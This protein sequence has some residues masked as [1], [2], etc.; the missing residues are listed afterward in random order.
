MTRLRRFFACL[1]ALIMPV[2]SA[3]AAA[4]GLSRDELRALAAASRTDVPAEEAMFLERPSV[5]APYDAGALE[6]VL[7]AAALRRANFLRAVAG[8]PP[9]NED[10]RYTALAQHAAVLMAAR[11][12]VSHRP[13]QPDDMDDA[14]FRQAAEGAAECAL[15]SFN[16]FSPT[17][18]AGCVD[19]FA[20]DDTA[21]NLSALAHRRWLLNPAMANA[22]FGLALDG[23][24]RSYVALYVT[25]DGASPDYDFI[26]WP[27]EGAFPAELMR[28]E[29][30]WSLSPNPA[31]C[32]L[33]LGEP[34]VLLEELTSGARWAFDPAEDDGERGGAYCVIDQRAF[35]GG[36]ALIFRPDLLDHPALEDGYEQNQRWRVTVTGLAAPDGTPL[37]ALEYTVEMAS[38]VPLDAASVE[39]NAR[40]LA[41]RAGETARID[42][43][44]YPRWADDLSYTLATSDARVATVDEDGLVTAVGA[45]TCT[46]R[47]ETANGRFDEIEITVS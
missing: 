26:R 39:L 9:V 15:A 8:L 18:A 20:R 16:W 28:H 2:L 4:R 6:P 10:L 41:L 12:A 42:A 46:L 21:A 31:A 27:A 44:V 22:G 23:E 24:G 29:T 30:P 3:N 33:S 35:A 7:V 11:R 32:D 1:F 45:G 19:W 14:F 37:D 47:A 34:R 17:L 38:L 25:D 43:T 13:E 36:P 40:A 5:A